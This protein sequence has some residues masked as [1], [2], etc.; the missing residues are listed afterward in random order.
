MKHALRALVVGVALSATF[1]L[2]TA[3]EPAD[4]VTV[5]ASGV[6]VQYADIVHASYDDTLQ[7]AKD[8][9]KAIDAFLAHPSA[10]SQQGAKKAWL[11]ARESYGQTEAY[12]FYGGPIDSETGPEE[13]INAW[14]MDESYVDYV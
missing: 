5:N 14:P 12:R 4:N 13:R 2:A 3:A 11:A 10:E 8:M 1:H 9:Q 6:L 7:S